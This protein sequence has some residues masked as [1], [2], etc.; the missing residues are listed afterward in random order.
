MLGIA[1][2]QPLVYSHPLSHLVTALPY[3]DENDVPK[4]VVAYMVKA[5]AGEIGKPLSAYLEDFKLPQTPF[6]NSPDFD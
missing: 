6:L 5:E 4:S 2:K 3:I 1:G